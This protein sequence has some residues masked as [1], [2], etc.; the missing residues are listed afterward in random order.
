MGYHIRK[1]LSVEEL[2][3]TTKESIKKAAKEVEAKTAPKAPKAPTKPKPAPASPEAVAAK[4]NLP[5]D[6]SAPVRFR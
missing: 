5:Y 2:K 4:S 3:S 6:S 1:G